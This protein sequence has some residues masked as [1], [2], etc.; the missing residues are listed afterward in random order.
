MSEVAADRLAQRASEGDQRA[1]AAIY[2]RYGDRL[3]RFCL[4][5]VGNSQDAQDALQNTMVKVL[6]AL[7]GEKR[8]IK[9]KPWLYR[10]AHNESV[11]LLRRRRGTEELDPELAGQ[12]SGLA[13]E[14]E[15]RERLRR[16]I[17]D[18]EE[19][20]ERQRATLVMRE[21]AGLGFAEIG[22]A[23]GTTP[24]T[25]RQTLYE[26]R[27]SLHQMDAGREMSCATVTKALSDADGRTA[28]RREIRAHLRACPNCRRFREE[29]KERQDDFAA[30][31]P[32]PAA[33]AAGLLSSILGGN[34]GS[35]GG[36]LAAVLGGGAAKVA[37]TSVAVKSAATVAVVAAVGFSATRGD[38]VDVG[39]PGGG[40]S[41]S[42][43][44]AQPL[45]GATPPPVSLPATGPGKDDAGRSGVPGGKAGLDP[46]RQA[47]L[48]AAGTVPAETVGQP[49]AAASPAV[50]SPG[51]A[52]SQGHGR[53][54]ALPAASA[55]GQ[56]TAA[57]HKGNGKARGH[58]GQGHAGGAGAGQPSKNSGHAHPSKPSHPAKSAG[59]GTKQPKGPPPQA[60]GP[61]HEKPP[62][63]EKPA[64]LRRKPQCHPP[65]KNPETFDRVWA[66]ERGT[67]A[68]QRR[69]ERNSS[70]SRQGPESKEA[71]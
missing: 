35:A 24:A 66:D 14:A 45:D 65:R 7:P 22:A 42:R 47:A 46:S 71:R 49:G 59:N 37:G 58:E 15:L 41:P 28:R 39:L 18:M 27:L 34:G 61:G 4:A 20:P 38:L 2:D 16:L 43:Q 36:G 57:A 8:Q 1:F 70:P 64:P 25:A 17:A 50:P 56:Q 19:L 63:S 55:H 30:L 54:K 32:L 31:S 21:L 53:E 3:Y 9:L 69:L 12:G 48:E 51:S 62:A 26:A 29:L 5:I 68:F 60:T 23:L 52:A 33:V 67:F 11:E 40:D 6:R 13:E 10:I 44:E